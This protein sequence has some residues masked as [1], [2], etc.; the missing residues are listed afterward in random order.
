MLSNF[1]PPDVCLNEI[2]SQLFKKGNIWIKEAGK[3]L[4]SPFC[5]DTVAVY[6]KLIASV[7]RNV[8]QQYLYLS[9]IIFFSARKEIILLKAISYSGGTARKPGILM[10]QIKQPVS[11]GKQGK[12]PNSR[13][14]G[15]YLGVLQS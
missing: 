8:T 7:F 1:I 4:A 12:K 15:F 11:K 9:T 5:R 14:I 6:Q 10:Q 13:K 2:P 3:S